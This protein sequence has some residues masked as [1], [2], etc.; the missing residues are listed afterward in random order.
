MTKGEIVQGIA[1]IAILIFGSGMDSDGVGWFVC[2]A[3]IIIAGAVMMI[4]QHF[5]RQRGR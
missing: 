1:F 2:A 5:S 4:A 3:G